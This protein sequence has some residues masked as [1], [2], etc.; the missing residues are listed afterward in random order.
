[1]LSIYYLYTTIFDNILMYAIYD[2]GR[3]SSTGVKIWLYE[4]VNR[5]E[6]T[7]SQNFAASA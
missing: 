2:L 5:L 3:R 4:E 1:M 6:I 7:Q